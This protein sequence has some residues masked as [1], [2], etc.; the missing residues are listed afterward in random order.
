MGALIHISLQLSNSTIPAFTPPAFQ[1]SNDTV[2]VNV[3]F[4]SSLSLVLLDAFLA[5]LLKSSLREFNRAWRQ[6]NASMPRAQERERRMQS[7]ERWKLQVLVAVLPILIQLSLFFFFI[8]LLVHIFP[9]HPMIGA[10]TLGALLIGLSLYVMT[11]G[12]SVFDV[13]SPFS[14]PLSRGFIY[15]AT[16]TYGVISRAGTY[17]ATCVPRIFHPLFSPVASPDSIHQLQQGKAAGPVQK[18][19]YDDSACHRD[20]ANRLFN[21][22]PES[23]PVLLELLAAPM[24]YPYLR[25]R[26]R[27]VWEQ[28]VRAT[29]SLLGD[30]EQYTIPVA[31]IVARAFLPCADSCTLRVSLSKALQHSSPDSDPIPFQTI[32]RQLLDM[33]EDT[34]PPY[35][36]WP[37]VCEDTRN[38]RASDSTATE[39]IWV[40]DTINLYGHPS[41]QTYRQLNHEKLGEFLGSILI[42]SSKMTPGSEDKRRL[43]M[44]V[45]WAIRGSGIL[46]TRGRS[47][48]SNEP[49]PF[50]EGYLLMK[51]LGAHS[52]EAGLF[53]QVN[54]IDTSQ[55]EEEIKPTPPGSSYGPQSLVAPFLLSIQ[56]EVDHSTIFELFRRDRHHAD[57]R[58]LM[59]GLWLAWKAG[60]DPKIVLRCAATALCSLDLAPFYRN[61]SSMHELTQ[62][63]VAHYNIRLASDAN[64]I[65]LDALMLIHEAIK[66]CEYREAVD[67]HGWFTTEYA[68]ERENGYSRPNPWLKLH[69]YNTYSAKFDV[70][71]TLWNDTGS[72]ETESTQFI[73]KERLNFYV[74]SFAPEPDL[75]GVF[76]RFK[77]PDISSPALIS[78]ITRHPLSPNPPAY[79]Q[80]PGILDFFHELTVEERSRCV[81]GL[82]ERTVQIPPPMGGFLVIL[83]WLN[84]C[85][86]LEVVGWSS[87]P[88]RFGF[89]LASMFLD[90]GIQDLEII[91]QREYDI[92]HESRGDRRMLLDA[93]FPGIRERVMGAKK[94]FLPFLEGLL[95]YMVPRMSRGQWREISGWWGSRRLDIFDDFL[96][97]T[98]GSIETAL[99]DAL[100][101]LEREARALFEEL[102]M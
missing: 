87:L 31:M 34:S 21:T 78:A 84:I 89:A 55:F 3:L 1:V 73:A 36:Q 79:L 18:Y 63:F 23:V 100:G 17:V 81:L 29:V 86:A 91:V 16:P 102:P 95:Q 62:L 45:I 35:P 60:C 44:A 8:G 99:Q 94:N 93:K 64:L 85:Q 75:L 15:L 25:P 46:S 47:C 12:I 51:G 9:F 70:E 39:L 80:S 10:L 26:S 90:T 68:D 96:N 74:D 32:Y 2:I 69:L 48:T 82:N 98:K 72:I 27:E 38:L 20:I 59:R 14:T 5:V 66:L 4:F 71:A 22:I 42:Y 24:K 43:I 37:Q 61:H 41:P 19:K 28:L 30:P 13:Y 92:L 33:K 6:Y 101:H 67:H 40:I 52:S 54:P 56:E 88:E 49:I 83:R 65:T 57:I 11:M 50:M 97:L 77:D 76:L 58:P 7:L 53:A